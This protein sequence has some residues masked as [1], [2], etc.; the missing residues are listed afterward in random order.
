MFVKEKETATLQQVIHKDFIKFDLYL[1]YFVKMTSTELTIFDNET[2]SHEMSKSG[3][4]TFAKVT[5][6]FQLLMMVTILTGNTLVIIATL[7]FTSLWNVTGL[8][9]CNL[10]VADVF[11]GLVLPFQ[12]VFFFHPELEKNEY[13]C[14]LRFI[15]VSFSCKASV[16]S[17]A[18]TV[19]DRYVAIV[20]PLKYNHIMTFKKS[21]IL[22]A[23]IWTSDISVT[24]IPL[25]GFNEYDQAKFCI[26]QLIM[27]DG[28]RVFNNIST[29]MFAA[30][31]AVLY[32]RIFFIARR[33]TKQIMVV[34]VSME[35]N[36]SVRK[37]RHMNN[38]VALV[39]ILFH[40]AW[41][42]Y[43]CL[44]LTMIRKTD[45]TKTKITA[46]GILVFLGVMNSAINPIIYA[47]KNKTYRRAFR[48]IL[49]LHLDSQID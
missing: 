30:F 3:L 39:V 33:H 42:P 23:V 49:S 26:F 11:M 14:L 38:A 8:F 46:S 5:A 27:D 21:Y 15:L 28:L 48:K 18:C 12:I 29:M 7:K 24:A 4:S 25:L 17:L 47:W 9:V 43:F 45:V 36:E 35:V 44:Q 31:M 41:L 6:T 10:A 40:A 34:E 32:A 2:I 1:A 22:I 37:T 13:C 16:Y 20:H 19:F